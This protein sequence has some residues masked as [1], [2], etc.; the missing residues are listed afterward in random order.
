MVIDYPG[1]VKGGWVHDASGH[2]NDGRVIGQVSNRDGASVLTFPHCTNCGHGRVQPRNVAA[3]DVANGNFIFGAD[4]KI[5]V[6]PASGAGLNVMQRG[7][8][9]RSRSQWKLQLDG[10]Q[11]S[12]RFS[13]DSGHSVLLPADPR[14]A[15]RLSLTAWY[16]VRCSRQGNVFSL[17]VRGHGVSVHKSVAAA[18]GS[19]TCQAPV[20][21]GEKVVAGLQNDK[22]TD[23]FHGD[24]R[25]I[26]F[27]RL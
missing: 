24:L 11:A 4:V 5:V 16:T 27:R 7:L 26:V 13:D 19:I 18:M 17:D 21:I 14:S 3:F 9:G 8:F 6:R 12:C 1:I 23:Q 22:R 20:T 15:P 10:L 25:N 2:G